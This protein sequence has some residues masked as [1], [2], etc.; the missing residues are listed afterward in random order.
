MLS[1]TKHVFRGGGLDGVGQKVEGSESGEEKHKPETKNII[2]NA[3]FKSH[4][5]S[6]SLPRIIGTEHSFRP[7]CRGGFGVVL[8]CFLP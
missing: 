1:Q 8:P 5:F 7:Y 6:H 2:Y 4:L 3:S